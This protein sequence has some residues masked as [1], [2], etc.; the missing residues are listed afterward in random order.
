MRKRKSLPKLLLL[1]LVGSWLIACERDKAIIPPAKMGKL[2]LE[3]HLAEAYAQQLPK[4]SN[5]VGLKNQDSLALFQAD[6]LQK[7]HVSE[8][9][10]QQSLNWYKT[11]PELLDSI[12][13]GILSEIAIMHSKHNK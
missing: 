3:L 7:L 10:F 13:Q 12:Y 6:I 11:K 8:K 1:S 4:D 9:D 2:L 5:Q